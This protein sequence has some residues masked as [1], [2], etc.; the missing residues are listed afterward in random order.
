[1]RVI[2]LIIVI[3]L[4]VGTIITGKVH[5]NKKLSVYHG[6]ESTVVLS[7]EESNQVEEKATLDVSQYTKNLP[8]QVTQKIEEAVHKDEPIQFVILGS[9]STSS[10][11]NGWPSLLEKELL[12]TYGENVFEITIVEISDK[13][14]T[15]V[16]Q[17]QLYKEVTQLTPDLLLFEPFI[18]MDNGEVEMAE[19][20]ENITTIIDEF[21]KVNS[22][23]YVYLQPANPLYNATYYPKE[24]EDLKLF[25]EQQSITYLNHWDAWPDY[26]TEEIKTYLEA[27]PTIAGK[28]VPNEQ[29]HELWASFLTDYFISK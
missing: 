26:R 29:G 6:M 9:K 27:D 13:T 15:Q 22:S 18:L 4:A 3:I 20:L 21:K 16:V 2:A 5:W 23:V 25:A 11:E 10:A 8:E 28:S 7:E 14:S 12:D 24:V 17:E 19:R 1:M